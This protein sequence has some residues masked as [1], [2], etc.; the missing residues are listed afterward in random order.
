MWHGQRE[1]SCQCSRTGTH[2]AGRA[3][4]AQAHAIETARTST[5]WAISFPGDNDARSGAP[6]AAYTP[7]AAGVRGVGPGLRQSSDE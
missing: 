6:R 1:A 4:N 2:D 5:V 3:T 7:L